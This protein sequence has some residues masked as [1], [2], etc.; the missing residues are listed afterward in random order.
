MSAWVVIPTYNE[1]E[2]LP[3]LLRQVFV[4]PIEDL[5]VLIVDD[6]SPDGTG[7]LADQLADQHPHLHVLHHPGKGG[8]ARAYVD[9]FRFALARGAQFLFEMDAD[10]SHNP[11]VLPLLYR[12]V[13]G[14]ADLA[15]GSRYC[16][17]GQIR[18]WN[19]P[20]R[21]VSRLGNWYARRILHLPIADLT[22]GFKCYRRATIE[23]IDL[24]TITSTGYNFQIELTYK[25]F[26]AGCRIVELPITFT[27]RRLG[28]SKF[29]F[30][31]VWESMRGVWKLRSYSKH[32]RA[33]HL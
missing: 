30:G 10:F 19:W 5:H 6:A 23:C 27:E 16:P 7:R 18:N 29:H 21:W 28:R 33:A 25:A 8:L 20:R 3:E 15:L 1:R 11:S 4:Q 22:G 24:T 31:I 14:D 17:G 32:T 26:L 13:V 9:G 12:S 2:N